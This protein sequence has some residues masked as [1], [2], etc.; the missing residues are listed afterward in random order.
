[1][2]KLFRDVQ[3]G[4]VFSQEGLCGVNCFVKCE[5]GIIDSDFCVGK[6]PKSDTVVETYGFAM[7]VNAERLGP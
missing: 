7:I 4:E 1:M 6:S 3:V 2:K 5:N